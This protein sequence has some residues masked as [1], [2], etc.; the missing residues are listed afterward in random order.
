[1]L[2]LGTSTGS[3]GRAVGGSVAPLQGPEADVGQAGPLHHGVAPLQAPL[4]HP[5]SVPV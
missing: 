4:Q 2:L 1:M 5:L 3:L